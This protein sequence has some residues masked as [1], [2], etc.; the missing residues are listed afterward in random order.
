MC[1]TLHAVKVYIDFSPAKS[2]SSKM[3]TEGPSVCTGSSNDSRMQG[4]M[5]R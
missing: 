4:L 1:M 2:L 3:S 5:G